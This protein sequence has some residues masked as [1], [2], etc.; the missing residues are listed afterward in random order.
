MNINLV[1]RFILTPHLCGLALMAGTTIVDYFTFKIFCK[2]M[3]A[4]NKQAHGLIPIM[5]HYGELVRSGA[6]I[7]FITLLTMLAL[8][9][10]VCWDQWWFKIKMILVLLLIANGIFIGNKLGLKF[11]GMFTETNPAQ[12]MMQIRMNLNRFYI[13]QLVIFLLIILTSVVRTG[14]QTLK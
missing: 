12:Q 6:A 11:R 10:V 8:V 4:N 14:N 7:L 2:M 1:L 5:A 9:K 3:D 13:V